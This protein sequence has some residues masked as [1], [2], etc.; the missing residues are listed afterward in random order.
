MFFNEPGLDDIVILDPEWLVSAATKIICEF[1]IHDLEEH[2][3][4]QRTKAKSWNAL[5]RSAELNV[6][7][8]PVLW[9][10]HDAATRAQLL[11]LMVKFG[12]AV[13]MRDHSTFLIPA[14]LTTSPERVTRLYKTAAASGVKP[15]VQHTAYFVFS[16]ED[17]LDS[18]QALE[19]ESASREGFL[20]T[21][22]FA[23]VLGKC[24]SWSQST[25]GAPV[26]LSQSHAIISF[27]GDRALLSE[28]PEWNCIR[29]LLLQDNVLA[30]E[31]CSALIQE[32]ISECMPR[33]CCHL[34][35]PAPGLGGDTA[36]ALTHSPPTDD[37]GHLLPLERIRAAACGSLSLWSGQEQLHHLQLQTSYSLWLPSTGRL[38]A[39][40]L[41]VSY[42]H[43][44]KQDSEC[45][46]KLSDGLGSGSQDQFL[47]GA[48][49]RRMRVFLDCIRLGLG[50]LFVEDI[51]EAMLNSR[52]VC[53][54]ISAD[55]VRRME[56]IEET[57]AEHS[58]TIYI[59]CS[60]SEKD[61]LGNEVMKQLELLC[62]INPELI[63]VSAMVVPSSS[64]LLGRLY[65]EP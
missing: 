4:A 57:A 52:V 55:A 35:L 24:V 58:G 32:V 29:I 31:R 30:A 11:G 56:E 22:F 63:M 19:I 49:R 25:H 53:P 9:S 54:I 6:D 45:A 21:G 46:A 43:S 20:P 13:P 48:T 12:L 44:A 59:I 51:M 8:L 62:A 1:S 64:S 27:G 40:E 65:V 50:Q 26:Q 28:L 18:T 34:M 60:T 17:Q 38:D 41:L 47:F 15:D 7:L 5:T 10:T 39:Y 33:L 42:R 16:L 36:P 23:R 2:R 37:G 14:L 3:T 61:L